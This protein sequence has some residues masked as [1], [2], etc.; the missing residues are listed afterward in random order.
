MRNTLTNNALDPAFVAEAVLLPS[1]AFIGDQM[2]V[3][4]PDAINSARDALRRDLGRSLEG[5]RTARHLRRSSELRR[6]LHDATRRGAQDEIRQLH[7]QLTEH[8][9]IGR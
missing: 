8:L 5:L 9:K 4:D 1:E 3:V 6:Q 7:A 2:L